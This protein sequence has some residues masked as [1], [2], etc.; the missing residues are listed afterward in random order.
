MPRQEDGDGTVSARHSP[1]CDAKC[2]KEYGRHGYARYEG[3][4]RDAFM[5]GTCHCGNLS[6][7]W[8]PAKGQP[9]KLGIVHCSKQ[10][11]EWHRARTPA[12][13]LR[14]IR[15]NHRRRAAT[16][17]VKPAEVF[18]RDRWR[19]QMCG[20]RVRITKRSH[21]KTRATIDHIVPISKGGANT[22][23]N[24]QTA[25]WPCNSAKRDSIMTCQHFLPYH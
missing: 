24:C 9:I 23:D 8:G 14:N 7:R 20:R 22:F 1:N 12:A 18:E 19:C 10:C 6:A 25:C 17:N 3:R 13:K 2:I 4:S 16:G 11:S 5:V 21:A 15:K